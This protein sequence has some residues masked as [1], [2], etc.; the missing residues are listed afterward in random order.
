[1]IA[2][3][4]RSRFAIW[5]L[6]VLHNRKYISQTW[7]ERNAPSDEK[8][9]VKLLTGLHQYARDG[10]VCVKNSKRIHSEMSIL[11]LISKLKTGNRISTWR[12]L[13]LETD[14]ISSKA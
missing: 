3:E 5:R 6:F 8:D 7:T 13:T 1:M 4:P 11:K 12:L 2:V 9:I 10:S 14:V